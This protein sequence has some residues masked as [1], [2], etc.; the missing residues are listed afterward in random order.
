MK[1]K[2]IFLTLSLV[3]VSLYT[4]S[5]ITGSKHDF[6][7]ATWNAGTDEIC[8][9]CHTPHN[10]TTIAADSP[11]WNHDNTTTDFSALLYDSE[12]L[13]ATMANPSGVSRLCLS[14]HDGTIALDSYGGATGTSF[15]TTV[16]A[17]ASVG[18]G[19]NGLQS[20]HP[21]SFTYNTA[22]ATTDGGLYDPSTQISG[23][24]GTIDADMLFAGSVE[25]SSCHDV[26]NAP[27][28]ETV[29]LLVKSNGSSAL[30]MTCHNK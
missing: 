20:E 23:L 5:Q 6:S 9:T 22:L 2:Q 21:V 18:D 13:D 26:H 27:G 15:I 29:G 3:M 19:V 30:C 10:S 4:Y 11:L 25:C 24:G 16:N 12:T 14:C 28:G 7:S 8:I 17:D 1:A